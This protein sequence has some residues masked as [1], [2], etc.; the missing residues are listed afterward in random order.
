MS[1]NKE[2]I[3]NKEVYNNKGSID[4]INELSFFEQE[5][6]QNE[7]YP[8]E[9]KSFIIEHIKSELSSTEDHHLNNFNFIEA[10]NRQFYPNFDEHQNTMLRK[11]EDISKDLINRKRR[12]DKNK[13]K[14]ISDKDDNEDEKI[15]TKTKEIIT[16]KICFDPSNLSKL[17]KILKEEKRKK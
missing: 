17:I 9:D 14:E 2:D 12:R 15:N 6:N 4:K 7:F 16:I 3:K 5:F 10:F 13:E 11:T 1:F 8:F